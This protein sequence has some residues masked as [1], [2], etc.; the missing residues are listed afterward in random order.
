MQVLI[1][2][3]GFTIEAFAGAT[4]LIAPPSI[5]NV[6]QLAADFTLNCL[7][8]EGV[9]RV[10]TIESPLLTSMTGIERY[11]GGQ[12]TNCLPVEIYQLGTT[13]SSSSSS[14]SSSTFIIL[15]RS[16]CLQ[17]AQKAFYNELR[18][19]LSL[20]L[21]VGL[22]VVLTGG[23]VDELA[24]VEEEAAA[25]KT[26][27]AFIS[28]SAKSKLAEAAPMLLQA[29]SNEKSYRQLPLEDFVLASSSSS[30]SSSSAIV[31]AGGGGGGRGGEEDEDDGAFEGFTPSSSR[32]AAEKPTN[33]PIGMAGATLLCAN[34]A[35]RDAVVVI[36]V[37]VGEGDNRLDG[38]ALANLVLEKM[39]L[40]SASTMQRGQS[41][42]PSSWLSLGGSSMSSDTSSSIFG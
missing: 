20:S 12:E 22:L 24:Q 31:S 23:A 17:G 10:A 25:T 27:F 19:L 1:L 7:S 6:G 29:I 15:Q 26:R 37:L 3:P 28:P 32:S 8:L 39:S 41:L 42:C 34:A 40:V 30:S 11:S 9:K 18:E 33:L 13:S 36:G 21:R 2:E 5:G 14:S 16:L 38:V 35:S 4:I